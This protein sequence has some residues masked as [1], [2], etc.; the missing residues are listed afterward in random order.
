[1]RNLYASLAFSLSSWSSSFL[2]RFLD[3]SSCQKKRMM[4]ACWR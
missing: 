2:M 3:E 1:M 4:V